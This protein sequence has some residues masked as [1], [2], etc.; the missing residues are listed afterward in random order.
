VTEN[1]MQMDSWRSIDHANFQLAGRSE[2]GPR[3]IQFIDINHAIV[4]QDKE[5]LTLVTA[6]HQQVDGKMDII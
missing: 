2:E 6:N 3:L 5:A 1:F 4:N